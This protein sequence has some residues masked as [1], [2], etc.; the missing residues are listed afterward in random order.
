AAHTAA[1]RPRLPQTG[2]WPTPM[3][4]A[5]FRLVAVEFNTAYVATLLGGFIHADKDPEA[6]EKLEVGCYAS[7]SPAPAPHRVSS[8]ASRR[9]SVRA[10]RS[11]SSAHQAELAANHA[12]FLSAS[13]QAIRR[14]ASVRSTRSFR[15]AA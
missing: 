7:Y 8:C 1:G 9:A 14:Y 3:C 6:A 10:W 5:T 15:A 13:V 2:L 4:A 11:H 12:S